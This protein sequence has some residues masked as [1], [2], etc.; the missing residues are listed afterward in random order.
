[1][2]A[3]IPL[4]ISLAPELA[5]W[6]FSDKSTAAVASVGQLVQSV[7]GTSDPAA[8]QSV[9][10]RD[11]QAASQLRVQLAQLAA[12]QDQLSRQAELD[13]L[14]ARFKDTADAR[15]QT[16]GL[17]ARGSAI[18]YGAPVISVIVL[19]TFGIV[20]WV[21]LTQIMPGGSETILNMLLG[22]LAAMSTSVVSY[23]VGSSA[24]SARKDEHIARQAEQQRPG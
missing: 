12:Q 3:L 24:G 14:V 4:V 8:A 16:L 19:I 5:K 13:D 15:A 9:L 21:A 20:M 2:G 6:L 18:A 10:A 11:P 7:T 22:T 23:W 17:A 1:M